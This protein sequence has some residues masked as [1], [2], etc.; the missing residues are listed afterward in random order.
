MSLRIPI[1]A[2]NSVQQAYVS[3]KMEFRKFFFATLWGTLISAVIGIIMAYL[4]YGVWALVVQYMTNTIIDTIVLWLTIDW[5]P[6]LE[7]S[8]QRTK[9]LYSYGWKVLAT[10]LLINIYGNT[11]DLIIGKKFTTGDLAYCNKGRQFPNLIATNI[12][13]SISKVL[14]PAVAEVQDD[15]NRVRLMTR[16]AISVGTYILA[17]VLMGLAA[18]A[19]SFIQ[20]IL[21]EKWLP[22]V[23]YLRITCIIF[24][25][26]PIQMASI[27]AMKAIGQSGIYLKLEIVKKIGGVVILL[28]TVLGCRSVSAIIWGSLAAEILSTI[29][30]FPANKKY[31]NYGYRE[32]FSDI[33]SSLLITTAMSLSVFYIGTIIESVYT[34]LFIQILIGIVI[35]FLLSEILR[36]DSYLYLK[37]S[38]TQLRQ[39]TIRNGE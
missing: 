10:S 5:K 22:C 14:F 37:K 2:I 8:W 29:I 34:R 19:D 31:F 17:P 13:T 15:I 11:Q 18:I 32:Q 16:R 6:G 20:V 25:L 27:Q 7:F 35:Y 39:K 21:T 36:N 33:G 38:V 23:P 30:N 26:Q 3:R 12:N 1:A 4:D 9:G 28:Y 24:L